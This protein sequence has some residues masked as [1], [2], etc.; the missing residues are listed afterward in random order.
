VTG[1]PVTYE[2]LSD[3]VDLF[4]ELTRG[5]GPGLL[6]MGQMV[7]KELLEVASGKQ[8]KSEILGYGNFPGIFTV[9]P[10]I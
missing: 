6:R 1:N 5:K 7:Y 2:R 8:T 4:V 3:Y 9:G 10:I